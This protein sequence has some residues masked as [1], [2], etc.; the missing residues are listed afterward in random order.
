L[1]SCYMLRAIKL[2][3]NGIGFVN[4]N[5]LV[6][7]VI[8]RDGE[9]IGEG[10]HECCGGLHAERNALK[11]CIKP[12]EG[13]DM[14]VTLEPCCHHGKTP[15]CTDAVIE[16]GIKRV[17]IGSPDPNPLVA[18]KGVEILRKNGI[19][20]IENFERASCDAINEVFFHYITKKTPYV[21]M[22]YAMTLDGKIA[23]RTGKSRWITGED[24]RHNVHVDRHRYSAI[25]TGIG[26]VLADDPM[27]DCRIEGGRN[28]VRIICDTRLRTPLN[29]RIVKTAKDIR[30]VIAT[31]ELNGHQ[32]YVNMGCELITVSKR[33]GHVNLQKLMS[34]LGKTGL[35]SVILEGG[36]ELNWS[37]LSCGTV[38]RVQAYIAPKIFG[39]GGF[40]PVSGAGF[41]F[42]D[43]SIKLS[44]V[45]V[46]NIGGDYLIEGKVL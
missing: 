4:P 36:G 9:I 31:C 23:C 5:P 7:A 16:S 44:D 40:S 25:M 30:T 8:V 20:V 10:Y 29:S 39:G 28:P 21:I 19:E 18:G 14:Y 35:D 46:K 38:N 32:P 26:T 41:S 1:N 17:F 3:E 24:A 15:P 37:A 45:T 2:A 42:P 33:D 13:A 22:K 27:L 43:E 12:P 11:N 6:G 34:E